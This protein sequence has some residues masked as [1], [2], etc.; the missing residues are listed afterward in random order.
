MW[1]DYTYIHIHTEESIIKTLNGFSI[2]FC[3]AE[4]WE[5][6]RPLKPLESSF[7]LQLSVISNYFVCFS[8]LFVW[9]VLFKNISHKISQTLQ[10]ILWTK[11][12]KSLNLYAVFFSYLLIDIRIWISYYTNSLDNQ[13]RIWT[14]GLWQNKKVCDFK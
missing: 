6:F 13:R 14:Y 8:L 1:V 5:T 9:L 4:F 3:V 11:E 10:F 7:I 12:W 2:T